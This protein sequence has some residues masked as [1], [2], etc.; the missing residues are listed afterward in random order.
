MKRLRWQ[1]PE[2]AMPGL[3]KS[4]FDETRN[5]RWIVSLPHQPEPF[6]V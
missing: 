4:D 3:H 2:T 5:I 6:R 1:W